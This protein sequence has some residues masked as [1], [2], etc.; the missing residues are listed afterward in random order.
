MKHISFMMGKKVLAAVLLMLSGGT[1][2]FAQEWI[3]VT[4]AYIKNADYSTG[5]SAWWTDGTE[6]PKVDENLKNA[7]FF[8]KAKTAAQRITGLSAGTY[9]LTV[10]GFYR[11]GSNNTAAIDAYKNGTEVIR[12]F[13]FAG[14]ASQA[15]ASLYSATPNLPVSGLTNGYPNSM[16]AMRGYC[17]ADPTCYVNELT[18]T[19]DNDN[20]ELLVGIRV[21][22]NSKDTWTC[23]DD[24]KLYVDGTAY[25]LLNAKIKGLSDIRTQLLDMGA[26][27]AAG[28]LSAVIEQYG[29]YTEDTPEEDI[30]SAIAEINSR[31]E[32][33]SVAIASCTNLEEAKTT[34]ETLLADCMSGKYTAAEQDRQKLSGVMEEVNNIISS[35]SLNELDAVVAEQLPVINKGIS[36]L[37]TVIAMNYSLVKAKELADRIGGLEETPEYVAV[38]KALNEGG[39]EYDAL[40]AAV[41]GLNAVCVKNMTSEFFAS[42]TE[43]NPLELTNFIVNPNICQGDNKTQMPDGWIQERLDGK[44]W[45]GKDYTNSMNDDTDLLCYSWSGN[46]GNNVG[47][48]WYYQQIGGSEATLAL[49][50]GCYVLKAATYST[51]GDNAAYLYVSTDNTSDHI[52]KSRI[53]TNYDTYQTARTNQETTTATEMIE[54]KDGTLYLGMRGRCIDGEGYVGGSGKYWN[55]DNFRL[56]YVKPLPSVEDLKKEVED[57][58]A[59]GAVLNEIGATTAAADMQQL[60][61]TY[62]AYTDQTTEE[63][64]F[65]AREHVKQVMELFTVLPELNATLIAE[66]SAG[67]SL[68]EKC[69]D[70]AYYASEATQAILKNVMD[71][72]SGSVAQAGL[73]N[74]ETT[75]TAQVAA[76]NGSVADLRTRVS[77]ND[78]L[79]KAKALA[80]EI[81][82]LSDDEAYQNLNAAL[83]VATLS[84]DEMKATVTALNA[85]C[86]AAMTPAFLSGATEEQPIDM[87]SFIVNPNIYQNNANTGTYLAPDGWNCDVAGSKDNH[88]PT[89]DGEADTDLFCYSWSGNAD[90]TI[91]KGWYYQQIGGTDGAVNLPDGMY[92]L[93]AATYSTGGDNAAYLYVGAENTAESV[94]LSK[95][96]TD[97]NTYQTACANLST[98]TSTQKVVVKGGQ[99]YIGMMGRYYVENEYVWG[100]GKQ[101]NADNFR[102]YYVGALE[103]TVN[104]TMKVDWATLMLPFDAELQEGMTAYSC[105]SVAEDGMLNLVKVEDGLKANVPYIIN[106]A[107]GNQFEFTG[108]SCAEAETYKVGLLTG[109]HNETEAP[110]ASYVLQNQ[111]SDGLA[112]YRVAENKQP[113]VGANRA[114]LTLPKTLGANVRVVYFPTDTDGVTDVEAAD[115]MVDVYT[116][117][118]ICVR[119]QVK[120]SEALKGLKGIYIL[121]NVK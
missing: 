35:T 56:Y 26:T 14:D 17:D 11:A 45:D 63:E 41:Q 115:V 111:E 47:N 25:D 30:N 4:S 73:E 3:D 32:V 1:G 7:E 84:Y 12:A 65:A 79:L 104:L 58:V 42:V 44:N 120:K 69:K 71:N 53:N 40:K 38:E 31:L 97:E 83:D 112:F 96:N 95:I 101:W 98:T 37:R 49:P 75:M 77:F 119:S 114:Y 27:S 50:R 102:L 106:A 8:Q 29:K 18:F 78:V 99:L 118:G 66:L 54:V 113:K 10:R 33:A 105:A 89:T 46:A 24:F 86:A 72:A 91:G 87:T 70:G 76:V 13:L 121:K 22:T 110:V 20:T 61:D 21:E 116:L 94:G 43:E 103:T 85:V 34:G 9:K 28:E 15:M 23:W 81:T 80:D 68:L 36:D 117:D 60:A 48:G 109:V 2:A 67:T 88:F 6:A 62:N 51:G 107:T 108:I 52:M 100:N 57:M 74:L 39:L 93:K 90:N 64:V 16:A 19:V 82:G 92:V 5:T 55:A 59:A